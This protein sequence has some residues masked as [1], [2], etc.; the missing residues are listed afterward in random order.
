LGRAGEEIATLPTGFSDFILNESSPPIDSLSN[1]CDHWGVCG[2]T[3]RCPL[4]K[5]HPM[6][7]AIVGPEESIRMGK[8]QLSQCHCVAT[9]FEI[10]GRCFDLPRFGGHGCRSDGLNVSITA[11]L[12]V[13]RMINGLFTEIGRVPDQ[14]S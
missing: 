8:K 10:P 7:L 2:E 12:Y 5:Y 1:A 3:D 14:A 13:L 6:L 9:D 11:V 4:R